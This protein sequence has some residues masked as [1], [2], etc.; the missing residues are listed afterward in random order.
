MRLADLLARLV[1]G[2]AL[3]WA[4]ADVAVWVLDVTPRAQVVNPDVLI[5]LYEAGGLP[6]WREPDTEARHNTRCA[7]ARRIVALGDSV[8]FGVRVP[9]PETH[10]G[11]LAESLGDS[12]VC[13][14]NLAQPSYTIDQSLAELDAFQAAHGPVEAV[15]GSGWHL[16]P[17][18]WRKAAGQWFCL[19]DHAPTDEA[20]WPAWPWGGGAVHRFLFA[21]SRA[22]R[23]SVL[24]T[25][26]E[27]AS[28]SAPEDVA[29][30]LAARGPLPAVLLLSH[31]ALD[32]DGSLQAQ[33]QIAQRVGWPMIDG[34]AAL[35][36]PEPSW[37]LDTR[38]HLTAEGHRRVA[39]A[40]I[41]SVR[42]HLGLD[43]DPA[44][45]SPAP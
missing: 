21:R 32:E 34:A 39:A 11:L 23:W 8:T 26:P 18:T 14:H 28:R 13:V 1:G 43:P 6:F 12:G 40:L 30:R 22:Y 15:I 25:Q 42:A 5:T 45:P 17:L 44:W 29:R 33:R 35:T 10:I 2:V 7:S 27:G 36:P 38:I 3:F 24:A 9:W 31:R 41:P 4:T 19:P 37:W 20:G 16:R